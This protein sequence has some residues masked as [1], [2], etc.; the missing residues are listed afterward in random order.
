VFK[1]G[2]KKP[3]LNEIRPFVK[4]CCKKMKNEKKVGLKDFLLGKRIVQ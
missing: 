1:P 3:R 2:Q 4:K